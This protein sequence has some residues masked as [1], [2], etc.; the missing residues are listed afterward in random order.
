VSRI[1]ANKVQRRSARLTSVFGRCALLIAGAVLTSAPALKACECYAYP[2]CFYVT[3]AD[4]IFVGKVTYSNDDGSGTFVQR[5]FI[6]FEVEEAFKGLST[7]DHEVWIDPGSF[8]SCYAE[9]PIG[10]RY[11]VFARSQPGFS[12]TVMM[13]IYKSPLGFKPPPP[14]FDLSHPPTVYLATECSGTREVRDRPDEV[15]ASDLAYLRAWKEGKSVTRVYGRVLDD[16]QQAWPDPSPPGLQGATVTLEGAAQKLSALTD[17]KGAYSFDGIPPGQYSLEVT[18]DGYRAFPPGVNYDLAPG[19]C[20]YGE[21]NMRTDGVLEGMADDFRG[22][23]AANLELALQRVLPNGSVDF[24]GLTYTDQKGNFQFSALP[25]GDFRL[26]V[27][28]D[29]HPRVEQPYARFYY[30]GTSQPTSIHLELHE[31]RKGLIF[32]LP[33]PLKTRVVNVLVTWADSTPVA[34]ASVFVNYKD[35]VVAEMMT[36]TDRQGKARLVC[37]ADVAYRIDASKWL[38]PRPIVGV[39][40]HSEP[41]DLPGEPW[42]GVVKLVIDKASH[43]P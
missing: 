37:L 29:R 1:P 25:R 15:V 6:R 14:G 16:H 30:P 11:L 7:D 43:F 20:G 36:R 22:H 34:N 18:L 24:M 23:P 5:T 27:N 39:A 21:F 8:T 42:T 38:S 28:L 4:V 41:Y 35:G 33:P 32:N 31:H 2:A 13:S 3:R 9:Y 19:T 10:H 17:S 12:N 40:A 26:G